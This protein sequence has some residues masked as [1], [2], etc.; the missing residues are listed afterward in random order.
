MI[1]TGLGFKKFYNITMDIRKEIKKTSLE[2]ESLKKVKERLDGLNAEIITLEGKVAYLVKQV[3]KESD[4]IELLKKR[5]IKSLFF[6]VLG[7]KEE[8]LEKERQ[9]YLEANL[10]YDEARKSLDLLIYERNILEEKIKILPGTEKQYTRL[11][12]LRE[13][14]I[15]DNNPALAKKIHTIDVQISDRE[16]MVFEIE[17]ALAAGTEATQLLDQIVLKLQQAVKWGQWDMAG[18]RGAISS[19]QKYRHIDKAK[20]LAYKAK[21]SLEKFEKELRDVYGPQVYNLTVKVPT[22]SSFTDVFFDN[23]ITDWIVQQKIHN[24]LNGVVSVGD[25]TRRLLATLKG[26]LPTINYELDQL[27]KAREELIKGSK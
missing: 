21:L 13:K 27:E 18:N 11:L 22:F 4:D 20:D 16:K 9:E 26:N 24:T 7:S 3:D 25:R 2:L 8:Q 12:Q 14:E 10:Q 1:V 17:E 15:L 19:T 5:G 23:L 6:K